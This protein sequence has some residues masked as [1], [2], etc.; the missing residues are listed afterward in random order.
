[1]NQ[2]DQL[3]QHG[4]VITADTGH[5]LEL[6]GLP[7]RDSTTNPSL[8]LQALKKDA[9]QHL[10]TEAI[11]LA[12]DPSD[13]PVLDEF[14]L[15]VFAKEIVSRLPPNGRVSVEADARL[16]FDTAA[17]VA[18]ARS[19]IAKLKAHGISSDNVLIKIASTWEG[20]QAAR[21]LEADGIHCNLTLLFA[22]EQAVAASDVKATLVS[23]FVGRILDYHKQH[24]PDADWSG[25]KDP[26]VA[27]VTEI[28]N[29]YKSHGIATEI[30][31]ASFRN[32]DEIRNL[33]GCDLLTISPKLI[34]EL[35][36]CTDPLP[37]ALDAEKLPRVET[38]TVDEVRFRW[39]MNENAMATDK[40]ADGIRRFTADTIE[41]EAMLSEAI[42]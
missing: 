42:K 30:M 12:P 1:M 2:L 16:S 4:T 9:Y 23:P 3:K 29:Y 7:V 36:A 14:M 27:S 37:K 19:I 34:A 41:M 11:D 15:V 35:R 26:G 31:G 6:A 32:A 40:L 24:S 5:F 28:F 39:G 33:A 38:M 17:T 22:I 10:L 8:I 21:L 13:M 18:K 20:I 25:K